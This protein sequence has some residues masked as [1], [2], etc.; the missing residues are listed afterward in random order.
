MSILDGD[1]GMAVDAA[2]LSEL[3][4]LRAENEALRMKLERKTTHGESIP[5]R[6][7]FEGQDKTFNL[8]LKASDKGCISIYGTG[9]FPISGYPLH[10]LAILG[11]GD[12]IKAFIEEN[13][14]KLSFEKK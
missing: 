6:V 1:K 7:V 4:K 13:K 14:A 12:Q 10:I 3:A 11:I 9:R 8:S 2:E 5:V